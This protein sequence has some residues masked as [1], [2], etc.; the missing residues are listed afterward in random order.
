MDVPGL[1]L[2]SEQNFDK[3]EYSRLMLRI[4]RDGGSVSAFNS[5]I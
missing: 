2:D 1:E 5:S 3:E 4:M